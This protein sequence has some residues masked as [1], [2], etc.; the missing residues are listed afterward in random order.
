VSTLRP[1]G[2]PWRSPGG[3]PL[4]IWASE[5]GPHNAGHPPCVEGGRWAN[6]GDG[7]WWLYTLATK[8]KEGYDT[9]CR[10]DLI[11]ADY[12]LLDCKTHN[13]LPDYFLTVLWNR[14]M[15][16]KVL[17]VEAR[18]AEGA[19][20]QD[21]RRLQGNIEQ[22]KLREF[23]LSTIKAKEQRLKDEAAAAKDQ[24]KDLPATGVSKE[25][26]SSPETARRD[27]AAEERPRNST[28]PGVA[29]TIKELRDKASFE[30][31]LKGELGPGVADET[32]PTGESRNPGRVKEAKPKRQEISPRLTET[33]NPRFFAHCAS[34]QG[35]GMVLGVINPT[36]AALPIDLAGGSGNPGEL[37][38]LLGPIYDEYIMTSDS[39]GSSTAK[40]NG[41]PLKLLGREA[42]DRFAL[43]KLAGRRRRLLQQPIFSQD[44]LLGGAQSSGAH[45]LMP[46]L[47]YGF[48]HFPVARLEA[49]AGESETL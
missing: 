11:G 45:L 19:E 20:A 48:F 47:S 34:A 13:P 25:K 1:S 30:A 23:L 15:G 10:Q 21:R 24:V 44:Q 28:A 36:D 2:A 37:V 7:F 9:V 41:H 32:S 33:G 17:E 35:R 5:I 22:D 6:F 14:L 12:A 46:P 49:C 31:I 29:Q 26:E 3:G 18:A 40:L 39:L 27:Q 16:R 38:S 43:P 4:E 8:A 42:T